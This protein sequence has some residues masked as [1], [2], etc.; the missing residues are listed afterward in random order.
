MNPTTTPD[1]QL[2]RP[3]FMNLG[4]PRSTIAL[5]PPPPSP[6][7]RLQIERFVHPHDNWGYVGWIA[8]ALL[9]GIS[10]ASF[11]TE[12]IFLIK[13]KIFTHT[14]TTSGMSTSGLNPLEHLGSDD[15][16]GLATSSD[17]VPVSQYSL[18]NTDKFP[19]LGAGA[20]LIGDID[21]GEIIYEHNPGLISPIASVSKL[22]TAVIAKEQ[23]NPEHVVTVS[24]DA[25]DTFG[26]EGELLPGEQISV[27][28]LMY[29]L[30]IESSNDGAE[31]LA[32][33]YGYD[34][35]M[36]QMNKKAKELGMNDTYYNEPS[37]L[38]PKNVSSV[39]DLFTL[40]QYIYKNDPSIW[41][42]T[43]IRSFSIAKHTWTNENVQLNYTS[44]LGG[45]NGFIDQSKQT[46][47]SLFNAQ[48]AQ[49]DHHN[50]AIVILYSPDRA[51]DI[52]KILDF[53]KKNAYFNFNADGSASSTSSTPQTTH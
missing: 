44:F 25:Y 10:V 24:Q 48:M 29:P 34:Q 37:G 21:T 13:D 8:V 43:K 32:D 40:A 18:T 36:I 9:V 17:A 42:M 7:F 33:D 23:M 15:A 41:D 51:S 39:E 3:R 26:S 20:Y 1:D 16:A 50:I 5:P 47:V 19:T 53:L 49:G 30:L 14:P 22:M 11:F 31:E 46:T 4:S 52:S 6:H 27:G 12:G 28:E 2:L 35:F 38:D 45:K